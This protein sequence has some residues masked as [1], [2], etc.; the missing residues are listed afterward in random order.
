M[1]EKAEQDL[2]FKIEELKQSNERSS[3]KL[4]ELQSR[5]YMLRALVLVDVHI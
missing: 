3:E 1:K 5:L 2:A 4:K